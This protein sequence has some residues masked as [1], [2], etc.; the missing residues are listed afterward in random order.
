MLA[1]VAAALV[2]FSPAFHSGH[3]IPQRYTCD[4]SGES[5]PLRWTAPPARTRSFALRVYDPDARGFTHWLAW[6]IAAPSRGI[7]AGGHA[8]RAGTNDFGRRGFG[9][10]CP[11]PGVVHRYVFV[12]YALARPLKLAAGSRAAAFTVAVQAAGVL[13]RATLIGTYRR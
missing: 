13:R 11:P 8:P 5:P 10:P 1:V 2:L 9:A 7:T 4:G 3:A 12:L 6:G